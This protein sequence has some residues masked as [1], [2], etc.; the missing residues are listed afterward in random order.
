MGRMDQSAETIQRLSRIERKIEALRLSIG[1]IEHRQAKE[2]AADISETEFQV[3]SQWGEDGIIQYLA[4]NLDI[5]KK[6]F[7]EFGVENY[8]ESNTRFLLIN[9]NWTGL[10]IDG[11]EENIAF[12]RND[13]I[14]WKYNLK[15]DCSF[16][17]AENINEIILRNGVGG[18]IGLLSI[19]MDGVDYWVWKAICAVDPDIVICEY[20]YRFGKERALTVPYD[21]KFNRTEKHYSNLYFGA[22]IQAMARLAKEKG[23][24]LVGG[25]SNGNN[26][27][28]VRKDLLNER[29]RERAVEEVYVAGQFRESR[30]EKGELTFLETAEEIKLLEGLA[31]V[32][33]EE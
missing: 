31:L 32:D 24:C 19:D 21:P 4:D 3:F 6:I 26:L 1:R 7:V 5:K 2:A 10:V 25:N 11:D 16:I 33:L 20:N 8:K 27:F 14:Y 23:Y 13:E 28:F 9:N 18:N 12:I 22:S 15:A 29:V 17:T 30:N